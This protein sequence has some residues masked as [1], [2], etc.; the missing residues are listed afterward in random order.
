LP[1]KRRFSRRER[2]R[3]AA[4]ARPG[5]S[6]GE[7]AYSAVMSQSN[8]T[9]VLA[10]M[11]R[12][13]A[14]LR[15]ARSGRAGKP[16]TGRREAASPQPWGWNAR[17]SLVNTSAPWPTPKGRSARVRSV[18]RCGREFA[19]RR[20]SMACPAESVEKIGGH[21]HLQRRS[22]DGNPPTFA[23]NPPTPPAYPKRTPHDR[24]QN[25]F[26]SPLKRAA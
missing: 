8:P 16:S 6:T 13:E 25:P 11:K 9:A 5:M 15:D 14:L 4:G 24:T 19:H 18:R 21:A 10:E 26:H 23:A 12:T 7:P 3:K 2:G 1:A 22:F 20:I 17:R